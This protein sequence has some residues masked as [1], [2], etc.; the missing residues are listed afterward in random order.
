MAERKNIMW[1]KGK[2]KQY[3]LS[4]NNEAIGKKRENQD[5]KICGWG[6]ISSCRTLYTSLVS[7]M[8]NLYGGDPPEVG[9]RPEDQ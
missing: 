4:Y 7:G 8:V 2:G 9:G 6:R 3:H 1:K 5:L